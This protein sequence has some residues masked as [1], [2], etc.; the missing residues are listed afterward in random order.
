MPVM[1][2]VSA[3]RAIREGSTKAKQVPIIGVTASAMK[4]EKERYLRAGMN[5]VV[6]KPIVMKQLMKIIQKLL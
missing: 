6:A 1:D 3:T 5:A 2:G 4:D